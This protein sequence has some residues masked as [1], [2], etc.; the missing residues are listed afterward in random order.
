[1]TTT[2]SAPAE[3][4]AEIDGVPISGLLAVADRPRAVIVALHGGATNSA[5]FDCPGH[6][7]LSLLRTAPARGFTVLALDRPGYGSSRP[8]ADEF[9]RPERR[10]EAA[11][12]AIDAHLDSLDRG[13][14]IFLWGHS[15]G[16][17]L[18][19]R[20]AAEPRDKDLL[21]IALAGT[22]R[23]HHAEARDILGTAAQYADPKG[24]YGLIW[25]HPEIY[26][27][28]LVGGAPIA[29]RT[30]AYEATVTASWPHV[31]FPSL[32]A[33]V[34]VPVHFTAAEHEKV[35]RGDTRALAD[36]AAI[37][38]AAPRVELHTQPG[39]GHNLALGFAA[40]AYHATVLSF[41]QECIDGRPAR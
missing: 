5:Y 41:V 8:H 10:V 1:M 35:W 17:E 28:E 13:A 7:E 33:Q 40:A 9:A 4:V 25:S 34:E 2:E 18:T 36:V 29:S 15:L 23:E 3:R 21:G 22:G 31:E 14:G 16:C 11:H 27:P 6:P 24:V 37:F 39:A 30:P 20:L 12:A 26:P 38:T 19:M 32:A